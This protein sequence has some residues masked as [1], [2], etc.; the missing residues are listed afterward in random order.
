MK[1]D[2]VKNGHLKFYIDQWEPIEPGLLDE[3]ELLIK[4]GW[5]VYTDVEDRWDEELNPDYNIKALKKYFKLKK[6]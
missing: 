4:P 5:T 3:K 1:G 2:K 6:V